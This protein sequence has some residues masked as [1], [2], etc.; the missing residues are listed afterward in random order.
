MFE[1]NVVEKIKTHIVCS[2]IFFLKTL[3]FVRYVEKY[4]TAGQATDDNII[5]CMRFAC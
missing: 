4:S 3:P 5:R 2:I 1:T